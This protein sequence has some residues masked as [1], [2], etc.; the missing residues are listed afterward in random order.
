M[1]AIPASSRKASWMQTALLIALLGGLAAVVFWRSSTSRIDHRRGQSHESSRAGATNGE[2][3][4]RP[5]GTRDTSS[6]QSDQ[7]DPIVSVGDDFSRMELTETARKYQRL[8]R[9]KFDLAYPNHFQRALAEV[10]NA[11][12]NRTE[13]I[14]QLSALL[15]HG[16]LAEFRGDI[17]VYIAQAYAQ[18]GDW[19]QFDAIIR[20]AS[21]DPS[22]R[23]HRFE[24]EMYGRLEAALSPSTVDGLEKYYAYLDSINDH[25]KQYPEH[26][27]AVLLFEAAQI[28]KNAGQAERCERLLSELS[29]FRGHVDGYGEVDCT[30]LEDRLRRR[31]AF[32]LQSDLYYV[33]VED[34]ATLDLARIYASADRNQL[35]RAIALMEGLRKKHSNLPTP[36]VALSAELAELYI[37]Q[38]NRERGIDTAQE[39]LKVLVASQKAIPSDDQEAWNRMRDRLSEIMR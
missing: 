34:L 17:L 29:G 6:G 9:Y 19:S 5:G 36:D 35:D 21:S 25:K 26:A 31:P 16:D 38:G 3:K 32:A 30:F 22:G 12:A 37:R 2:G 28:C 20:S 10:F 18:L 39:A 24:I 23:S 27:R 8:T 7:D 15:N 1:T 4:S 11:P 13:R 33:R 14:A